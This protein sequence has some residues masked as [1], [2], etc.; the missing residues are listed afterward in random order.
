M[1]ERPSM[2]GEYPSET[3]H[4]AQAAVDASIIALGGYWPPLANLARLFEECG[5]LARAVNQ[6][7]G[8]KRI[9]PG[10]AQAALAEELGDALYT[11]LVLANSLEVDA[12]SALASALA[13]VTGRAQA[14]ANSP[15]TAET[16]GAL[17]A[18][19]GQPS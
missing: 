12:Q 2:G 3:L 4:G 5:E 15:E 19:E 13:K 6:A 17:E 18:A 7:Y 8:S 1:S 16:S 11:L 14:T 9:K 10:E